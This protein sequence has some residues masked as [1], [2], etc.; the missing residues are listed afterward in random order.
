M[1]VSSGYA[2]YDRQADRFDLKNNVHI[3]A[4]GEKGP[5]DIRALAGVYDQRAGKAWLEGGA[6]IVQGT[7]LVKGQSIYAELYPARTIKNARVKG[8]AYLKQTTP[9]RTIEVFG[10]ELRASFDDKQQMTA[11]DAVGKSRAVMTPVNTKDYSSVTMSAPQ[12][13]RLIFAGGGRLETATT[14]GRTTILL[15]APNSGN[16]ASSKKVTAD[17]VKT[18]FN[19]DGRTIRRAEAVGNAELDVDPVAAVPANYRTVINAPRFDCDFFPT[20]N[21]V[22]VCEA[23]KNTKTVRTPKVSGP[24][25]G[26]QTITAASL[27]AAFSENTR[28]LDK[29]T[30]SG[31]TKFTE[32]DRNG[33]ADRLEYTASD[34]VVRLRGGEP[35]VWDSRARGKA[36]EIDWDTANQRSFL[37]GGA[38]TTYYSVKQTS[39]A[40]P[41]SGQNAPVFVT[42]DSAEIDH[43][44]ETAVYKG[45]ARAWQ[46]KNYVRSD[47][48]SIR[49]RQGEMSAEGSVQSMLYDVERKRDGK[50]TSEPVY[51]T[52]GK[53]EYNREG[54][55]IVYERDV[56]IRQGID[57]M[58]GGIARIYLDG[59][60]ELSRADLEQNVVITQPGRRASGSFAR[61]VAA[62]E[63]VQLRGQPA[64]IEDSVRGSSQGSEMT[65]YLRD[66]R[67]VV[68]GSSETN[69]SGRTRTVYKI[70]NN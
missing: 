43:A 26:V 32:L 67:A 8:E 62:E 63:T 46:D 9:D 2:L 22:R 39:G 58:S 52:A 3:V 49:Q 60:N 41:F 38:S 17:V 7:E 15:S 68:D 64:R 21:N 6:E 35:T 33:S 1:N 10:D 30:A 36:A 45:N 5:A 56:S 42:A 24:T 70:K 65:M 50:T 31:G 44:A 28:D 47:V 40:V 55:V 51:A 25:R 20:G 54:N 57:R 16:D 27:N 19:Q 29:L 66:N 12:A 48:L 11:S 14:E 69:T 37:R 59:R 53:M 23:G 4:Q 18:F 13:L 34:R 61:Y